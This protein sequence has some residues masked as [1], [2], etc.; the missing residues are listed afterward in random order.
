MRTNSLRSLLIALPLLAACGGGA[1]D[2][3]DMP[4]TIDLEQSSQALSAQPN[5]LANASFHAVGPGGSSTTVTLSAP[6]GAD[7][8]VGFARVTEAP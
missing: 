2:A 6:G 8:Y 5:Y 4:G 1:L 7:F 3:P